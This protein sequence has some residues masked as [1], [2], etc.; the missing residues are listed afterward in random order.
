MDEPLRAA[1]GFPRPHPAFRALVRA[2]LTGRA[3]ALRFFPPRRRPLLP[4]DLPQVRSYPHGYDVAALGT[5]PD[6]DST[7]V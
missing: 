2:G 1:F 6:R 3:R 4:R 5:F 7:A